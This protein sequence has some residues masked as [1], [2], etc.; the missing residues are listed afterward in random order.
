MEDTQI[1]DIKED[2]II[3]TTL[4]NNKIMMLSRPYFV[5]LIIKKIITNC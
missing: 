5:N 4:I 3:K 1:F 2:E